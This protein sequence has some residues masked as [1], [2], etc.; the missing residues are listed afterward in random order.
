MKLIDYC[1]EYSSQADP[2]LIKG[3][4][5][6]FYMYVTGGDGVHAFMSDGLTDQYKHVGVVMTIEGRKEYWAPSVIYT[7]G[8]YY[9]YVSC[10]PCDTT[11]A[12]MQAMFVAESDSPVG[13]FVNAKQILE[14]F[15]IDSHVVENES[16]LFIFYSVNDYDAERAGT[17]VVVDRMLDPYTPEG[18]P[19][20][21]VKPTLDQEIFMRD[22]FKQGQHWHTLEGAFYF[23]EG[24]YHYVI[25][26][27]NCYMNEYYYLGYAVAHTTE[28]DLTKIK[29][30]KYPDENTY[31]PLICKNSFE[32]GTGHNSVI[33]IDGEYYAIYHGRD[34]E[35]DVRLVGDD[36]TARICKL[37]LDGKKMVALQKENSL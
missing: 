6:K 26:S 36:R 23:R 4:D 17:Y 5:G 10:I 19:V 20:T 12:H 11:D 18:K 15:S 37:V 30:E 9:M 14:P 3:Q 29:F 2:F 7:R 22:R 32:A 16:G 24:D 21:V 28:T 34:K 27:G 13:P 33:K 35:K 31:S 25:Y 1:P 8:R